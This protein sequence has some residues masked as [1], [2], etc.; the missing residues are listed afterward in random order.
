MRMLPVPEEVKNMHEKIERVLETL[1]N[2]NRTLERIVERLDALKANDYYVTE[3]WKELR[4]IQ[5]CLTVIKDSE[6]G[7][8]HV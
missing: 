4:E 7:R 3:I 1:S 8:A 6:I 5:N 2:Q